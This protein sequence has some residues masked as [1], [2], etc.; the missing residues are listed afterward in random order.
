M[1][2]EP[3]SGDAPERAPKASAL[4]GG[5]RS[6]PDSTGKAPAEIVIARHCNGPTA[7]IGAAFLEHLT[8]F[9]DLAR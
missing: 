4:S 9:S 2:T 5:T 6:D 1:A 7:K 3:R 8:K